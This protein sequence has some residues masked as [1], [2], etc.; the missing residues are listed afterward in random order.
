MKS[1]SILTPPEILSPTKILLETYLPKF[2]KS[3]QKLGPILT[4]ISKKI[5]PKV[6]G[7]DTGLNLI[8]YTM[9]SRDKS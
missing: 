1:A 5:Y 8:L 2:L 3:N 6:C 7:S 9:Q 4:K